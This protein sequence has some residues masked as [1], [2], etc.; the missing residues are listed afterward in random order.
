MLRIAIVNGLMPAD[1]Y[2][3]ALAR[4]QGGSEILAYVPPQLI[5]SVAL[6]LSEGR[7]PASV[8]RVRDKSFFA[9]RCRAGGV[10]VV[11]TIAVAQE[12]AV[13]SAAGQPLADALPDCDLI[14]KPVSGL[15][16]RGVELWQCVGPGRFVNARGDVLSGDE[17]PARAMSLAREKGRAML[18][19]EKVEN[20]PDLRPIAGSALA[21]TRIVTILNE[22]DTPEVVDAFYR[23]SIIAGDAVDNFH[24]GGVL[25]PVDITSGTL[26]PGMTDTAFDEATRITHHPQTGA[27]VAGR[28]HPGWEA[29]TRLALDLHRVFPELVMPGWDIGYD[30]YGAIAIEAND[31][32]GFSPNRQATFGGLVGT[33]AFSLLAYHA[34]RWLQCNEPEGS[35]WRPRREAGASVAA[36]AASATNRSPSSSTL[37]PQKK[38]R[39]HSS[40]PTR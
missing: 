5:G 16:G 10:R 6:Y 7:G 4:H 24:A 31:P 34:D 21:T 11:R 39:S 30:P 33:R 12:S 26:L 19:Q 37:S 2:A 35:R 32:P 1:Y 17:I 36:H 14:I 18:I 9:S 29:I 15:Q 40:T 3:A 38:I 20:H 23:T 22:A 13:I 8:S 27:M 25:F 28:V